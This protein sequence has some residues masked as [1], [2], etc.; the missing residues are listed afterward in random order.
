VPSLRGA[1]CGDHSAGVQ[2]LW[3]SVGGAASLVRRLSPEG[4]RRGPGA[5]RV[6]GSA[7]SVDPGA[8]VLRVAGAGAVA[9]GG[10]GGISRRSSRRRVRS[11]GGDV[12]SSFAPP[13]GLTRLRPGRGARRAGR[14]ATGTRRHTAPLPGARDDR[15]G[16]A[17][18]SPASGLPSWSVRALLAASTLGSPRRRRHDHGGH[19]GGMR[20]GAPRGRGTSGR[21]P[22]RRPLVPGRGPGPLLRHQ[23]RVV[24]LRPKGPSG[25]R[26]NGLDSR[27]GLWLPGGRTSGSRCQPQAKRPT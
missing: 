24:R 16:H 10:D 15:T 12:G 26:Y 19:R 23:V 8:E 18:R 1:R 4:H 25:P 5:L 14:F 27:L 17:D 3:P 21:G 2:A 6:R 9:C 13:Q 7:R 20:G 11:G 22:G